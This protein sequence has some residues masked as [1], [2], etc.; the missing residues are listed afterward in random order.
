[1]LAIQKAMFNLKERHIKSPNGN[2]EAYRG[3]QD[4]SVSY[5]VWMIIVIEKDFSK[6]RIGFS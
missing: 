6:L 4:K 5:I 2:K 3:I 1:M